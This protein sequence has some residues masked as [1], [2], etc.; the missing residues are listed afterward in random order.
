MTPNEIPMMKEW[1]MHPI[2]NSVAMT[3][4]EERGS[5]GNQSIK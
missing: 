4:A 1:K 5:R 2:S 3:C